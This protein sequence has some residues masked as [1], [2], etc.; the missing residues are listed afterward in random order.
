MRSEMRK[1]SE[2]YFGRLAHMLEDTTKKITQALEVIKKLIT[3]AAQKQPEVVV[4]CCSAPTRSMELAHPAPSASAVM[5][6]TPFK[7]GFR[8]IPEK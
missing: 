5:N 1:T 6:F 8:I 7:Y 2:N 3:S 4:V